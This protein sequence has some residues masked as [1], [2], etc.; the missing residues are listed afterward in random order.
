MK[1]VLSK[2][3]MTEKPGSHDKYVYCSPAIVT[4]LYKVVG[5]FEIALSIALTSVGCT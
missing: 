5:S 2:Q 1:P 3:H 4:P